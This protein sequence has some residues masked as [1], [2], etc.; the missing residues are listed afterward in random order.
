MKTTIIVIYITGEITSHEFNYPGV[1]Q[2]FIAI[3][4]N[5]PHIKDI[6]ID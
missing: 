5:M 1:A 3:R 2:K 6:Y 4:E